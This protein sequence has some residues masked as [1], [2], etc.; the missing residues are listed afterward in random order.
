MFPSSPL[1]GTEDRTDN[2]MARQ[3]IALRHM[4]IAIGTWERDALDF[5]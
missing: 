2:A 1:N 3:G 5:I 4:P